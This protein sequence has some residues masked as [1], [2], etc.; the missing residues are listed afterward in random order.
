MKLTEKQK[1]FCKEYLIDLNATQAAIRAGYSKK[2]A[3]SIGQK[4]LKKAEIQKYIQKLMAKRSARTEIDADYVLKGI[5]DIV[6]KTTAK[7]SDKL[8]GLELLGRH[9]QLFRDR[10]ELTHRFNL[11]DFIRRATEDG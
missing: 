5:R 6:E 4:L 3:Y 8:K 7:D 1:R 2:T 9:V 10:I 11:A